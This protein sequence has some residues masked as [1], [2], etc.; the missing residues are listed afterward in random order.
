MITLAAATLAAGGMPPVTALGVEGIQAAGGLPFV[1]ASVAEATQAAGSPPLLGAA[2]G[3]AAGGPW[4]ALWELDLPA[5]AVLAGAGALYLRG[6]TLWR[7][8]TGGARRRRVAAFATGWVAALLAVVSPVAG[9]AGELLWVHMVQHL[10]MVV[11]A[12]PLL[13]LGGPQSAT[14]R[15][16]GHRARHALSRAVRRTSLRRR[17]WAPPTVVL[18]AGGHIAA[19]WVWHAPGLYDPAAANAFVHLLEHAFF[20]GT[21]VWFWL[22]VVAA[23]RRG[24]RQHALASLTLGAQIATGGVL[25]ALLTF[26]PRSVYATY[27]GGRGL[28]AVE[29]QELAGTIMWVPPSFVYAIVAVGLFIRWLDLVEHEARR[30]EAR[31]RD[32]GTHL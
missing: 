21:A 20:L 32:A 11:V 25:G 19:L 1:V 3:S 10:L 15:A 24:R 28:S 13:A 4:W 26:A 27:D 9:L 30:R 18:A 5:V 22:A 2:T 31:R 29:D 6:E 23:T 7:R 16:L 8:D 14:R 17:A 12:A